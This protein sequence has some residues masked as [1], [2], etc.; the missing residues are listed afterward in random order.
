MSLNIE[1]LEQSFGKI[2]PHAEEFVA[3]FYNNLFLV[4]PEVKPMF[5]ETN[6]AKQQKQLLAALVFV[7][8]NLRKPE[9]L[10][11]TLEEMGA[12]HAVYGTLPKHYPAVGAALLTTFEQY[13]Q[14]DWTPAVKQAWTDAFEAITT[15]MLQG[16]AKLS[17]ESE[18]L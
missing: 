4:H 10:G 14:S 2:K 12:R 15:L 16:A 8:N 11:K 5:A 9:A 17:P 18:V 13:L 7:I 3:S 6:M 1:L